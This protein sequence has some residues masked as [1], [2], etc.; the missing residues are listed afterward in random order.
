MKRFDYERARRG[1]R[2]LAWRQVMIIGVFLG[3][4]LLVPPRVDESVTIAITVTALGVCALVISRRYCSALK[5]MHEYGEP[6]AAHVDLKLPLVSALTGM[7]RVAIS[8]GEGMRDEVVWCRGLPDQI[9]AV[10]KGDS[11]SIID[12]R[13]MA[14]LNHSSWIGRGFFNRMSLRHGCFVC[15]AVWSEDSTGDCGSGGT[16]DAC[17]KH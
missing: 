1:A 5:T 3:I 10:R 15:L 4:L 17:I 6:R 14:I 7:L 12:E 9:E 11:V 8:T 2:A 16:N 13:G